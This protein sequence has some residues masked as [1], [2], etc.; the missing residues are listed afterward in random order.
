MRVQSIR[1]KNFKRF[2]DLK[3]SEI[4]KSAK[5]VVVV[6]PNGCGKSSLFD[7]FLH[8]YRSAAKF[9]IDSDESY[10]RKEDLESFDWSKLVEVKIYDDAV[11]KR[12]SLYIRTAYRN[13]PEFNITGLARQN[14]PSESVDITRMIQNDQTV[15]R[16]YQRL[17]Y[18]TTAAVY[19]NANDG[20]TVRMLREELIGEVRASMRRV[21]GDLLLNN[22]SDPLGAGAFFFEKG[23]VK[24]YHYKNLSGGEKAAFD[25]ILDLHV[26]KKF[27]PEAVYCIDEA[28]TH[29]HT[30]IQGALLKELVSIV[31][32]EAQLWVTTHSLGVLRACQELD[33]NDPRSVSVIDFD[34]LDPDV[35]TELRP[36]SLGRVTWDKV[37]SIAIDDLSERM[38]PE[39]IVV[40]EGSSVGKR[41]K[42]FDAEIY[43]RIFGDNIPNVLFIS[44]GSSQQVSIA[45]FSIG[46]A[47]GKIVPSTKVVALADRDDKSNAEIQEFEQAGNIVL[48]KRNLETFLFA[49]D[50]LSKLA[51]VSGKPEM[52][53]EILQIKT[54]KVSA[55]VLRGNAPDDIKS[56]AGEI[57][58]EL[59]RLLTIQRPGNTVDAFM[60]DTLTPLITPELDTYTSLKSAILDRL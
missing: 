16:N 33:S 18:E 57:Y 13:D 36:S 42:D 39:I 20:K 55:S 34:G 41:R 59:K 6:G 46:S 27:F 10:F 3:I 58:V 51:E 24:S 5:L 35:P 8:W 22:I 12:G 2:S 45:G 52:I 4:P 44:G 11:P 60:R 53:P 14:S 29:L 49:D 17:V 47:L 9:G 32:D 19:D 25:L 38:A 56:A 30:R 37:M 54:D 50:V 43:N 26:K 31:P 28:E 7:G 15:A 21:F 1:L 48:P 23:I 40:C